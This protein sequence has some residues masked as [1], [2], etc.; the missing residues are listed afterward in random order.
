MRKFTGV[1]LSVAL[2]A[3]TAFAGDATKPNSGKP[4]GKQQTITGYLVD[5]AC[6]GE[7][8]SHPVPGFA[9]KHDKE[10]LQMPE[11]VK[12]GY[13]ILTEDNNLIKL[14]KQSSDNAKKLI[15]ATDKKD[16]WKVSATGVLNGDSFAAHS[17]K[18]E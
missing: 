3:S 8:A 10:C 1:M 4:D 5:V 17:L 2:A 7:N 11:C 12:S 14:D 13:G 9:A 6:G 15:A 18:L 16:N